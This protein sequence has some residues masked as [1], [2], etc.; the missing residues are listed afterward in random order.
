M[1]L[2]GTSWRTLV[3][4]FFFALLSVHMIFATAWSWAIAPP[5]PRPFLEERKGKGLATTF[6][7]SIVSEKKKKK[8]PNDI[9]PTLFRGFNSSCNK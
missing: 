3:A 4:F 2:R 9:M 5:L 1:E 6:P 8:N 7:K